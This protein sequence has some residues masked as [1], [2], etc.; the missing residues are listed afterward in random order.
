MITE[1]TL[2]FHKN[3]SMNWKQ[4][5]SV[6]GKKVKNWEHTPVIITQH[7]DNHQTTG[8]ECEWQH[9]SPDRV[10]LSS[11][12]LTEVPFWQKRS[13]NTNFIEMCLC[14][15]LIS[16]EHHTHMITVQTSKMNCFLT[17]SNIDK[18]DLKTTEPF[19]LQLQHVTYLKTDDHGSLI[20]K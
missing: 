16:S 19:N 18:W 15:T 3:R 1:S 12:L 9:N 10:S 7:A 11:F 2:C 14:E 5:S 8:E 13:E 17:I 6:L 20:F 4:L